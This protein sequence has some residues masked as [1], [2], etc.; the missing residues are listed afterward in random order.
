MIPEGIVKSESKSPVPSRI[1]GARKMAMKFIRTSV[2]PV[3]QRKLQLEN[4]GWLA[5]NNNVSIPPESSKELAALNSSFN[6]QS[7]SYSRE[8]PEL[9]RYGQKNP[10]LGRTLEDLINGYL[11]VNEAVKMITT[12]HTK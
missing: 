9:L 4:V 3:A 11:D 8:W 1:R 7:A 10:Q 12:P 2:N 5:A 6:E